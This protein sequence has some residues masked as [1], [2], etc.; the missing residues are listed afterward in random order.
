MKAE[1]MKAVVLR[2]VQDLRVEELP[3]PVLRDEEVLI[4]I[5]AAGI[6][7]TD[8][9]MWEGTNQEG[10]FP[11]VPGH[12]WV[13]EIVSKGKGVKI[14]SRGDRV[15]GECFIPCHQCFSCRNG[16][17]PALCANPKYF[18][19]AWE[20][21]GGMAEFHVSPVERLH[22]VPENLA[23]DVAV[24]V[25]PVSV[26]YRAVW[27][28]GGGVAPHDDVVI[29]GAGTIGLCALLTCKS[30]GATVIVVEPRDYRRRKALELGADRVIDPTSED[31]VDV[32]L[33]CT[34]QYGASLVIEC[35]GTDQA[36]GKS[37]EVLAKNGRIILIGHSIGRKVPIEIGRAVW[38]DARIIGSTD[39][40]YFFPK[41][42][43][44][45][46]PVN[47]QK[48]FSQI[49]T[50]KFRLDDAPSAFQ[51]ARDGDKSIKVVLIP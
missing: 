27:G 32:V 40:P 9:D 26:V 49:V 38:W 7:G 2:G 8:V 3:V 11:F 46:S 17:S 44:F 33:E 19:F 6:C 16:L 12:E 30:S 21:P 50:H 10:T 37:F 22:K 23:D 42:L 18:G 45:L 36:I 13:G 5:R 48:M 1:T 34:N 15:V 51:T 41:T 28:Q 43:K 4:R 47:R 29:F 35:S 25:E 20:T 39:S 31:I 14:F 24:L